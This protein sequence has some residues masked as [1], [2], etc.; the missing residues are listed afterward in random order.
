MA[1]NTLTTNINHMT[2]ARLLALASDAR[3]RALKDDADQELAAIRADQAR[4][5]R[6]RA[7]AARN[8]V[9]I[10]EYMAM[11]PLTTNVNHMTAARFYALAAEA[12]RAALK[13]D[14]DQA[15]A[16]IHADQARRMRE[17]AAI[18]AG[19]ARRMRARAV[20]TSRGIWT[21]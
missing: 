18:H 11:N 17:R 14:A 6:E 3:R 10:V 15:L 7:I 5:M 13:D 8:G 2:A 12:R 20:L 21:Y 1:M 4:R 9:F 16:A 19:Q